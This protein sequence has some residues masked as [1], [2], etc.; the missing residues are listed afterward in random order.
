MSKANVSD[1]FRNERIDSDKDKT[2]YI[3]SEIW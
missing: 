2:L 3:V 1:G